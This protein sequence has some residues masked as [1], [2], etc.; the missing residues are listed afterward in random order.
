DLM[1]APGRYHW[2]ALDASVDLIRKTGAMPLMNI[3]FKPKAL[4]PVID[5]KIVDPTSYQQWEQLIFEMVRHYKQRGSGIMYWEVSNEP[6]IGENGGCLYLFTPE[7]SAR[8]YQHTAS[9]IPGAH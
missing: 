4:Y 1:P 9:A 8:Y 5:E 3:D 2:D 7:T 6:D